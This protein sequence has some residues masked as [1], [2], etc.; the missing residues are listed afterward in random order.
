[1]IKL[2]PILDQTTMFQYDKVGAYIRSNNDIKSPRQ[3][4]GHSTDMT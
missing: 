2:V 4:T 1:M 3:I